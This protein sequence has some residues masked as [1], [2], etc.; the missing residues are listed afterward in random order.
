MPNLLTVIALLEEHPDVSQNSTL[1][2]GLSLVRTKLTQAWEKVDA[3]LNKVEA[4]ES[5]EA[6]IAAFSEA[7]CNEVKR[8]PGVVSA[9]T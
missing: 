3:V 4:G 8:I 2:S 1:A 9:D 5:R 6:T 7:E